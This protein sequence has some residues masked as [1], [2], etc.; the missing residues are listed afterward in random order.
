MKTRTMVSCSASNSYLSFTSA[1]PVLL[2]LF[3]AG[4]AHAQAEACSSV[5]TASLAL[6]N[7]TITDAKWQEAD[8]GLP[9]H[10]LLTGRA[11]ERI[12]SD[13][14]PYAI[15][16]EMRLP[17]D[18]KGRF[19][20]QVNGGNDGVVV[21][22]LGDRPDGGSSGGIVAL[23]RGFAVLSSDAGHNG[24]DPAH[25]PLGLAR[26]ASFGLDAQARRDYG[27]AASITLAPVAKTVLAAHYGKPPAYS[28]MAGCSNGGRHAMVAASRI[29][30]QFDGF[31]VGNPGFNLPRAAIQHAWDIQHFTRIDADVR[32]SITKEDGA[33]ISQRIIESCDELDG[34]KDGIVSH[35]AACQKKFSLQT[36]QCRPGGPNACLP[37]PKVRA[38]TASFAGPRNSKGEALYADW[39]FDGGVGMG[40]WRAWKVES[41]VA[42]WNNYP[43]I[44]TM[45]AASLGYIFTTP[46]M[47]PEGKSEALMASL[48]AYDFDRDAPKIFTRTPEYPESAVEFMTPPDIDDPRLTAMRQGNRKMVLFHGQADPVFSLNDTTRWYDKLNSNA[49]GKAA[50]FARLFTL[51]GVTHCGGGV[52]LDRLDA[53]TALTEWVEQGKA[54]DR[55]IASVHPANKDIPADWSKDRTRPLCPWPSYARYQAG[56]IEKAESFVCTKP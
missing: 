29:P 37:E 42:P 1:F 46:P 31:L 13:G 18:W 14:I 51:P 38:L 35:V 55:I 5:T 50:D 52:G 27:Y 43:I 9:R 6:A 4:P 47:K 15:R 22:A 32:K 54:P 41:S 26:G 25:A 36:L 17:A 30:D 45:G 56:D 44:A 49:E 20:Y 2:C 8:K 40:N 10:C 7:L 21:P 53:L 33:L 12:G 48:L 16:F 28:Y 11:N 3:L 24:T 34:V 39:P 23:A 19:L